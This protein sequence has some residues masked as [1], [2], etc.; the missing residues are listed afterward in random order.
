MNGIVKSFI[1]S[2]GFGFIGIDGGDDVFFHISAIPDRI[3]PTEGTQVSFEIVE[4][5]R[6]FSAK[7]IKILE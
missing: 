7:D 5:D 2:R 1:K 6:G 3:E 4:T